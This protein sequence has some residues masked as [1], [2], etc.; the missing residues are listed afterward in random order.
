MINIEKFNTIVL[1]NSVCTDD[2]GSTM[3]K[4]TVETK[5]NLKTV[6]IDIE[7]D[8][9][10]TESGAM[11]YMKGPLTMDA[12]APSAGGLLK[13]FVSGENIVRP[14]YRGSGTLYLEPSYGEFT[15][16]ELQNETWILD[17]G[18]YYASEMSID[19]DVMKN[20]AVAGLV[21][22]EGMFQ[23]K[24][25][26]TGKVVISSVGP[27]EKIELNNDKLVVDGSFA[28]ARTGGVEF[29]VAKAAKGLFASAMSGEGLVNTFEGTGTVLLC[30]VPLYYAQVMK[31][32]GDLRMMM[33]AYTTS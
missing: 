12:K 8:T 15:V 28:V 23:T 9:V 3:I 13:S 31:H 11:Y 18:A 33:G 20:K 5:E 24:V 4:F 14:T 7:N 27:L 1:T 6:K 19:I 32:F 16:L 21:S 2:R 30:P 17:K 25:S 26:G 22:G 10:R 29:K